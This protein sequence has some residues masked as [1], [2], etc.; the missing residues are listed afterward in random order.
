M[1]AP[2]PYR[3]ELSAY[4]G[5]LDLLLYLV[6]RHEIDLNDIPIAKLTDQYLQH[7]KV[8]QAM[9]DKFDVDRAGEFLVMAATLLEI[10]SQMLM[11]LAVEHSRKLAESLHGEEGGPP[12]DDLPGADPT[13]DITLPSTDPRFELVQQLLAYKRFKDAAIHLE[14]REH[15]W[16]RRFPATP[17]LKPK[18]TAEDLLAKQK[19]LELEDLDIMVLCETF[20]RIMDSVGSLKATHD[21]TY[22]DTPISLHADDIYDQLMRDGAMGLKKIFEG[23][24]NRS[25][26]IGLFLATLELVRTRRVKVVQDGVHD[27]LFLEPR[28]E[29]EQTET[30]DTGQRDWRNPETGEVEYEWPD[31]HERI[32]AIKRAKLKATFAAK[33]AEEE[34]KANSTNASDPEKTHT[35]DPSNTLEE[36]N[37]ADS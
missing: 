23:R 20:A 6:K 1:A 31:E 15:H 35:P 36:S 33:R 19:E 32:R 22:D 21:V 3:V 28:P 14:Q 11:P 24:T 13:D 7:V 34:A 30:E 26:M 4:A 37:R 25:E 9:D 16:A 17:A 18:Q 27:E 5:P 2:N 8:I 29:E 12:E 10:K